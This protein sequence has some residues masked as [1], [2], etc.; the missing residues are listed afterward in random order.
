MAS[1][2]TSYDINN[3]G[4]RIAGKVSWSI[5]GTTVTWKMT[6]TT[7]E[8]CIW[9]SAYQSYIFQG[10]SNSAV[11][12]TVDGK[13]T[14]SSNQFSGYS[15]GTR[16]SASGWVQCKTGTLQTTTT[17]KTGNISAKPEIVVNG[18]TTTLNFTLAWTVA[19]NGNGATSGSN[20]SQTKVR[21]TNLSLSNCGFA[22]TG[23]AF[24][25]WN[26]AA[27]GSGTPYSAE[28]T[29]TGNAGLTLYAQWQVVTYTITYYGNENTGGS[30]TPQTKDY[31]VPIQLQANG[32][33]RE[34][35][36]FLHWNTNADDS[37]SSY[38][39]GYQYSTNADLI[40]Y[41]IWKRANIPV[42]VNPDGTVHQVEK[43][44]ININD[45]IKQCTVYV[46]P[47]GTIREVV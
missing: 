3:D 13:S 47:D 26:T 30:T 1:G 2:S 11:R 15:Y 23:Y 40:L 32:F 18:K 39:P 17:L 20:A 36:V 6:Y 21:D 45:E 19:Y 34:Q 33:V 9:S 12:L 44:F 43:A 29:Y 16:A 38:N 42:F 37:G 5:S 41:A 7:Y 27:D 22:R 14:S 4:Y 25:G 10:K 31:N 8:M 24:T 35:Y 46:N 28:A